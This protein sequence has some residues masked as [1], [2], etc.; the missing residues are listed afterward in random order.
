MARLGDREDPSRGVRLSMETTDVRLTFD[1]VELQLTTRPSVDPDTL[2]TL[3]RSS[4][5]LTF[6]FDPPPPSTAGLRVGG[7]PAART[8]LTLDLPEELDGPPNLCARVGCPIRLEPEQVNAAFLLLR[9]REV[10]EAFQPADSLLLDLRPVLAPEL[11]PKSPLGASVAPQQGVRVDPAAFTTEGAGRVVAIPLSD[12]VRDLLRAEDEGP[13]VSRTLSILAF[14]EPSAFGFASFA[15]P[16]EA[17][18]PVLRLILT[19]AGEVE[20]P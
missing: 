17:G 8:I 20:H 16:D 3:T 11:L 2:I 18:E 15:G 7:V 9:T 1:E 6:V 19:F 12:Y 5:N 13:T 4:E 10:P 14:P